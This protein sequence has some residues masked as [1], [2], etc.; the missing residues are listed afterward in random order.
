V[1]IVERKSFEVL[2]WASALTDTE[3]ETN[4]PRTHRLLHRFAVERSGDIL[5]ACTTRG[6]KRMK[7]LGV[8]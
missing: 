3:G 5:M 7:F 4:L 1:W 6:L 8:R 2:G